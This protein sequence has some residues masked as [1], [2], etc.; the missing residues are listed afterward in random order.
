MSQKGAPD[1]VDVFWRTDTHVWS[2]DDVIDPGSMVVMTH[3][4]PLPSGFGGCSCR[5]DR[6]P[7]NLGMI[8]AWTIP[9]EIELHSEGLEASQPSL[10]ENWVISG[11]SQGHLP[12]QPDLP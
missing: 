12:G 2:M 1:S 8:K 11:P 10:G 7:A 5:N 6:A 9:V 3:I 4:A